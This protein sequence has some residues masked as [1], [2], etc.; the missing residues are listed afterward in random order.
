[1]S[2]TSWASLLFPTLLIA[3][4][5]LAWSFTQPNSARVKLIAPIVL[6]LLCVV[7]SPILSGDSNSAYATGVK[8]VAALCID[9]VAANHAN[10]VLTGAAVV[11]LVRRAW[12]TLWKPVPELINIL[13]VDV[14]DPPD[15]SLA[16]IRSDAATVNWTR[17]P[18]N[19]PV[20]KFLIQVNGVVVGE[21]ASNQ[22]SAIVV[23]GLKPNHFYNVRVIAVG[24]NNF[25]AGSRVIRLRTFT[26]DGRPGLGNSRLP[27]NFQ[28]DDHHG[29]SGGDHG[30]EHG[31]SRSSIPVIENAAT[32]DSMPS[33]ARDGSSGGTSGPRRNTVGRR[34][35]PSTTSLDQA[36]PLR[37]D[38]NGTAEKSLPELTERFESIRKE[39]EETAMLIAKED[40]ENRRLLDELEAEK[41]ERKREQKKKEEQ[42][43][44]LKREM[45][46]T[47]RT[48][49]D[50]MQR[51]A[52][53]E[54]V[55]KE[56]HK[57]RAKYQDNMSKWDKD[58]EKMRVDQSNFEQQKKE[59]EKERV[60]KEVCL[61]ETN[62]NL[63][64]DCARLEAELKE[65]RDQVRELEDERK[66]L[67]GGEDDLE[68]AEKDSEF[69][70]EWHRRQRQLQEALLNEQRTYRRNEDQIR[71]LNLQINHIPAANYGLYSQTNTSGLEFD[72][73]AIN[74]LKRRSRTSNS[75]S[76]VSLSSPLPAYSQID[77]N[78]TASTGFA[79]A[80]GL[81]APP[82]FAPGPYMDLSTDM[83]PRLDEASIRASN[84]PL[85]P[86]ATALLPSSILDDIDD[87]EPS[88]TSRFDPDPFI[89]PLSESP[90]NA[91]QSP[92]SSGRSLSMLSSPH[93]SSHNLPF[94]PF[95]NDTTDRGSLNGPASPV[96]TES[97]TNKLGNLFSFQR[98]RA[99]KI[100]D[101]SGPMLGSLKHGQSQS[102]PRQTDDAEGL[103]NKRR[104]SL[105][106]TWNMF[107]RN[108][109]GPDIMEGHVIGSRMFSAR[110]L[111]PFSHSHRAAS[112]IF[113]ARDPSSPRPA[114]IA[115]NEFPRPS[116]DSS[117]IWGPPP[118]SDATSL[119]QS[120]IW[121]PDVPGAWSRNP[122]RRPSL[123]G[124]PSA[125][126]T[127]LAS[128]DD[129]I[130][131]EETMPNAS[132]VGVIG[133]RLPASSKALGRLNPNA[134][135]FIGSLFSKS[136][137]DKDR[138]REKEAGKDKD[139]KSKDKSKDKA[140][141]AKDKSKSKDP[142]ATTPD[143]A[144]APSIEIES[145]PDSRKS[146]DAFS[147]NTQTS[148]S[149]SRESLSLDMSFSN[150]TS[151]STSTGVG[152]PSVKDE[153]VVRKL[154]RKGSSGKF[155]LPGR[156]GGKDSSLFKK[157]PGSNASAAN[158][159]K[160]L[161]TLSLERTSIGDFDELADET[162]SAGLRNYDS[163]TS[164]PSIG[165][166]SAKGGKDPKTPARWL[167]N[168]GKKARK[169][170]ESLDLERETSMSENGFAE[171][172]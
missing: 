48:M 37:E 163:V 32:Q 153:N 145:P 129:E 79:S 165:A 96:A 76:N 54:K 152:G 154:F 64:K 70:K 84:A 135:A 143:T 101:E 40:G 4:T 75:L 159:D 2:W 17:Y 43:E 132:Q 31:G 120:R 109:A 97:S 81:N 41:L 46:A 85:S 38:A 66:R 47:D 103:G 121:S 127:T 113:S 130:L 39:T 155:S 106:G 29:P 98:S 33:P 170:K 44:K 123:H 114:S 136:K 95:V 82:G 118:H 150:T 92:A 20:E 117:S 87:D 19:R 116:T 157:G 62:A 140:K 141:D 69:R 133:S 151:D 94:P 49:R 59:L 162:A 72:N 23:S 45:N 88:P 90:E 14:P 28:T 57:E 139:K 99:A 137:T 11:W 83:L 80:R 36:A 128:A 30:D 108:S 89:P 68:W 167:S 1:M 168:F 111:N 18:A 26:Q 53:K 8:A 149:E 34:H 104:I 52:Q 172:T 110:N 158:S 51:R 24:H 78:I 144:T 77:P 27:A 42:T 134:P 146:R 74:H 164:S 16:G 55:L 13:G 148:V 115:S 6:L 125:L 105:S 63:H 171:A 91:P 9:L 126:K 142:I 112:A 35:S 138:E 122:S 147:I 21:V 7:A 22:E 100:A 15:V 25:Q 61:Q 124:S 73:A 93:G 5:V 107:N 156:L 161:G 131:D 50:T 65:R 10:M 119:K 160:G 169:E 12:Q 60:S 58:M 86:S 102:F 71:I 166:T 3:H 56:K 67:P